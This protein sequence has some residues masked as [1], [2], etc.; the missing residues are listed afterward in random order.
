[1]SRTKPT[2]VRLGIGVA[3]SI[4]LSEVV[5]RLLGFPRFYRLHTFPPQFASFETG[6]GA[7]FYASLPS[8][9]I[10][11]EYDGNPRHYFGAKNEVVHSTNSWGFRGEE[12]KT[13]KAPKTFRIAFLGD[14]CTFGEGVK[15]GDTFAEQ[16]AALLRKKL[17]PEGVSVES[18]NFGVGGYNTEQEVFLLRN[19][20]VKTDPDIIILGYSLNDAEPALFTMD[21]DTGEL[22]RRPSSELFDDWRG[23]PRP[24]DGLLFKPRVVQLFWQVFSK[25]SVTGQLEKYYTSQYREDSPDWQAT[26]KAL[27]EFGDICEQRGIPCW[28]VIFPLL[29][30]LDDTYPFAAIHGLVKKTLVHPGVSQ[31]IDGL[32]LLKGKKDTTLWVHPTDQHPNEAVHHIV[33]EALA[34]R[35]PAR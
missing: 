12:F 20:V 9:K 1:V 4:L 3:L 31:V 35:L 7:S 2:L 8:T 19:I 16:T 25:R 32:D 17:A 5:L 22:T 6:D 24:P 21:A 30:H 33:A 26:K 18:Y 29:Y 13:E 10:V 15:D 34:Q 11:F 27:G 23:D 14:S 28:V